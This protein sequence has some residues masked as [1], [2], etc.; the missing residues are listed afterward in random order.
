MALG[1]EGWLR[2]ADALKLYEPAY[3][4]PGDVLD[5]G[6]YHGLSTHIQSRA[7]LACG[8]DNR[9]TSLE[10]DACYAETAA[11]HLFAA[12]AGR[13]DILVG[14]ARQSAQM[15]IAARRRFGF[16]FVDHSHEYGLVE[17]ACQQLKQLVCRAVSRC[18]TTSTTRARPA[19]RPMA[20]S[21]RSRTPLPM[22]ASASGGLMAAPGST[23]GCGA[24]RLPRPAR[25]WRCLRAAGHREG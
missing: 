2:P 10:L 1:I 11:T 23:G 22:A 5:L 20:C 12:P 24:G 14:D 3:F 17:A 8:E 16:A 18:S 6:T 21:R 7:L 19:A 15:L 25:D 9:M 4:A 13:H